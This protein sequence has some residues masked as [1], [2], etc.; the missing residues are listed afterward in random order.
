MKRLN[1]F[2]LAE[3]LYGFQL[4]ISANDGPFASY[5]GNYALP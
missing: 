5:L 4:Q 2:R 3:L 1:V